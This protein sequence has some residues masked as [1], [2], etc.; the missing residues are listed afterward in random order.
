MYLG[1]A[2]CGLEGWGDLVK[3]AVARRPD[4]RA[5][6]LAGDLVDRGNERSNWDHFFLRAAGVVDRIPFLPA[7]GN[8]E[9]LDRGP[10]HYSASFTLPENGPPRI[11]PGL[12]YRID[13]G[14]LRL[15]VLDSNLGKYDARLAANQGAWMKEQFQ[16]SSASWRVVMFHHPVHASHPTR[17]NPELA[18]A[19]APLFEEC[20]VDLVLQGH[21]HAYLRTYPMRGSTAC[22]EPTSPDQRPPIYVVSVSGEKFSPQGVRPYAA[23]AFA[24]KS[25]VQFLSIDTAK[26]TLTY[27]A[28]D[29]RGAEVDR[30]ALERRSPPTTLDR[31]TLRAT[32]ER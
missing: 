22:L 20:G 18:R 8:H 3:A 15:I 32:F 13:L 12:A 2:Q 29:A 25:T 1:D 9:Y 28:L 7:V 4:L 31:S 19:W 26:G 16:A 5:I 11:D 10:V 24:E 17:E 27:S 14:S 23:R 6:L 21:D 30:F